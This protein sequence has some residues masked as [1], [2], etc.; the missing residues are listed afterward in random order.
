MVWGHTGNEQSACGIAI[1]TF[2][3]R[4]QKNVLGVNEPDK[5][6]QS[7]MTVATAISLW[8]ALNDPSIRIGSPATQA[9][10]TGQAWMTSFMSQVNADATGNLRVD[11][12]AVHWY[13]WNAGSC[14]ASAS[15]LENYIKW[16]E[17][18]PGNR[19]IW[20]TEWGCMNLSNPNA[21]TV[22]TFFTGAV[23]MFAR[24][25]RIERY[26]WYPWITYN[27]LN[28]SAGA[29][30]ALGTVFAAQPAYE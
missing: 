29:L 16:V 28:D 26:A 9:N 11:F 14:E 4:G 7:N 30:T 12:L 24:H 23:A 27:E 19:P 5:S 13:G 17:A 6:G 8:P 10:T 18:I 21:A 20:I 3:S 25:P 2:V 15:T 1:A 22:Q